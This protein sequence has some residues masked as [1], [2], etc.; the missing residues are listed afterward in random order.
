MVPIPLLRRF[1]GSLCVALLAAGHA[2]ALDPASPES[3]AGAL[4]VYLDFIIRE[5]A[6]RVEREV[7]ALLASGAAEAMSAADLYHVGPP[8]QHIRIYTKMI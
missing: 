4:P 5:V 7:P 1:L 6:P 3:G 8:E 2:A